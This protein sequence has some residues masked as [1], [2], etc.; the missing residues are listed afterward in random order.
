MNGRNVFLW[1]TEPEQ[2]S[3]VLSSITA[4]FRATRSIQPHRQAPF[5][6]PAGCSDFS[7]LHWFQLF[8]LTPAGY[9][10]FSC[11]YRFQLVVSI[12]AARSGSESSC[13]CFPENLRHPPERNTLSP[14]KQ[15]KR[16]ASKTDFRNSYRWIN[17]PEIHDEIKPAGERFSSS[18]TFSGPVS[19]RHRVR[20]TS[21]SIP[22]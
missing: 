17:K 13:P 4:Y 21:I 2:T 5:F 14:A 20:L 22:R 11:S 9:I 15:F 16:K 6:L 8:I 19:Y 10:D 7:R 1:Q 18:P 12:P 3:A